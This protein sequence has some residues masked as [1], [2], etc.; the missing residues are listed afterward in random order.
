MARWK[1]SDRWTECVKSIFPCSDVSDEDA[2]CIIDSSLDSSPSASPA[3]PHPHTSSTPHTNSQKKDSSKTKWSVEKNSESNLSV[4]AKQ[5]DLPL[6]TGNTS[7]TMQLRARKPGRKIHLISERTAA[8]CDL[9]SVLYH[10]WSFKILMIYWGFSSLKG[11]TNE[12]SPM[13]G[14]RR[15]VRITVVRFFRIK[16]EKCNWNCYVW[17]ADVDRGWDTEANRRCWKIWS[18]QLE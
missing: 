4:K 10:C 13:S 18:R 6:F 1:I 2:D 17:V 14:Q 9:P 11:S 16:L 5:Q 7:S 15:R 8:V 12:N 3:P